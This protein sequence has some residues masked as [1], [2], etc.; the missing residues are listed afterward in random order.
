MKTSDEHVYNN[1]TT[2]LTNLHSGYHK[3]PFHKLM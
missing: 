2:G 1:L 3:V